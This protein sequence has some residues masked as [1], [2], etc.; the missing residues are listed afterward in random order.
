[1]GANL[2]RGSL[3]HKRY[4]IIEILG[5]GGMGSVYHALDEN[6]GVD[7]AVKENLFTT[8]EYARQFRLEAVILANLRHAN[9]PRVTDHFII[10]EQG[11]Y[12]IMD[13]IDGEDLRQR[14]ERTGSVSEEE[15]ILVGATMCDALQYLHTRK[16]SI[17]HRDLKPGNVRITP[18]GHI[19]LVDFGLAKL[20]KGSQA[21]TTG[22]RAMSPGY[23]PPEQYGTAR[24][25]PRTD[26]YS[27]GATL[28]AVLTGVIP[29]DGLA[30]AMDNVEL[31]PLRKRNPKVSRKLAAAIEKAMAVRP[32][33]RFQSAEEFKQALLT[34]NVKNQR[35]EGELV[36]TPPPQAPGGEEASNLANEMP[37]DTGNNPVSPPP[38]EPG[39]KAH[40]ARWWIFFSF[41]LLAI[42]LV[43]LSILIF[44]SPITK[45]FLGSQATSTSTSVPTA[46]PGAPT[47]QVLNTLPPSTPQGKTATS[48]PS[49]TFTQTLLPTFMLS[50]TPTLLPTYMPS[51]TSTPTVTVGPT[52]TSLGGGYGQIAFASDRTGAPQIFIMNADGSD[53]RQVTN[54]TY[55]ACQP[56]WSPDGMRLVVSSPCPKRQDQYPGAKL[57]IIN[58]DSSGLP[59][60]LAS[61]EGG[62]FDPAWS[63]DGTRIAFTSL[64][65]GSPQIYV[66]NLGDNSVTRLTEA[67]RDAKLP[68]WSS[69][70]AWS[71]SGT[72]IVYTGHSRLTN[73]PQIWVMS[74]AGQD[75]KILIPRGSELWNF[76]PDWS[77]DGKTILFSETQGAQELGWLMLFD[78]QT[79]NVIHLR[80]AAYGTHGDYSPDGIWVAY[81][82]KDSE[83]TSRLDYDIYRIRADGMGPITRLTNALTME[84]NPAWRPIGTP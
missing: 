11:Q 60:E 5:Q 54:M 46:S 9:L 41:L 18:D 67:S 36:V 52:P 81:E 70:P 44:W 68:D 83:N 47:V 84:F 25:D 8:G 17:I 79:A 14:M 16:P 53:P 15:A 37:S 22:A 23:S 24:T 6:L 43:L 13:Y 58:A 20:V 28:Y 30:R 59:S 1:M 32:E 39:T 26:I 27:L 64:R 71:P 75:Q 42:L 73:A 66:L 56:A 2:E 21:T 29:E 74:D 38:S 80:G 12:L 48:T 82:S 19:Y 10:G 65:D 61:V 45:A 31:T 4:R 49:I 78:Y 72:Q 40:S 34:S 50:I 51:I 76:L 35:L 7:V 33:D 69:Q 62:D 57:Y 63:P 77:L 3:L 55:G